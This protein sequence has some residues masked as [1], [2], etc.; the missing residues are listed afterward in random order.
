[1]STDDDRMKAMKKCM[2]ARGGSAV[3]FALILFVLVNPV[4]SQ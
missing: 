4:I 3:E 1:M 2:N